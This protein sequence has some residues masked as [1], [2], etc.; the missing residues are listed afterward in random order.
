MEITPDFIEKFKKLYL[1]TFGE[2]ISDQEAY[3][4]AS[5][6]LW[7]VKLTYKPMTKSQHRQYYGVLKKT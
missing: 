7:L 1:K 4:Q 2:K 5:D 3:R 6:L